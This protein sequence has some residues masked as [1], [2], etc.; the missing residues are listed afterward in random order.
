M[1]RVFRKNQNSWSQGRPSIIF[2]DASHDL[3]I[4]VG[5]NIMSMFIVHKDTFFLIAMKSILF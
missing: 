4:S 2:T 5:N 1:E 3:I